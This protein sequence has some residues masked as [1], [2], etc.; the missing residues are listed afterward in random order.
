MTEPRNIS[1]LIALVLLFGSP[2][3][4]RASQTDIE[5]PV[6]AKLRIA[7]SNG[8][9]ETAAA[10]YV[11]KDLKNAYYVTVCH[12][13][14]PSELSGGTPS[15]ELQLWNSPSTILGQALP[16]IDRELD[17]AVL[18]VPVS[19]LPEQ[20]PEISFSDPV[21]TTKINI[22][23]HPPAGNWSI[24]SGSIQN[25]NAPQGKFQMFTTTT[26]NSLV[27]GFSGGPVLDLEG[28]LIGM[29]TGTV[30]TSYALALKITVILSALNGWN[31][32]SQ[33]LKPVDSPLNDLSD[34]TRIYDQ[35]KTNEIQLARA[36]VDAFNSGK[37]DWA[38]RFFLGA[39]A[40]QTS[41]VWSADYPYLA[42]AFFAIGRTA[43]AQKALD[44]MVAETQR[45]NVF[46]SHPTAMGILLD[47]CGRV[48]PKLRPEDRVP[49]D[50]AVEQLVEIKSKAH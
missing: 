49:F 12:A 48:R 41:R 27:P 1:I 43:D 9:T 23:G 21:Q 6:V 25:T 3:F 14:C 39:R 29:H 40:V 37:F 19:R 4:G 24:W 2:A 47:N 8:S 16:Q 35:I 22:I 38:I 5:K 45:Q 30:G 10:I 15:V 44:E 7:R 20:L 32:P 28:N 46:L 34:Q 11:G 42:G 36:G 31:V 13:V 26:D 18:S 33:N 17:L 50:K